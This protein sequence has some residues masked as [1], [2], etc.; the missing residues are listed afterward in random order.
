MIDCGNPKEENEEL[1]LFI[2]FWKGEKES[3]VEK[4]KEWKSMI[5]YLRKTGLINGDNMRELQIDIP[6]VISV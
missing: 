2:P 3:G 1:S 4:I 6:E 5:G